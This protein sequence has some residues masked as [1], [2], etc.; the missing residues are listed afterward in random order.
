M[1]TA[2][3]KKQILR[4]LAGYNGAIADSIAVGISGAAESTA[5]T[6]LGFEVIRVPVDVL[7]PD[8]LTSQILFKGVLPSDMAGK[9]YEVGLWTS[10]VNL[11]ANGYGSRV[12][13]SFDSASEDWDVETPESTIARVGV[14]SL[15]HTPGA[16]ATTT[17]TLGDVEVDLSGFS[18]SD[19]FLF[20]VN[21]DNSNAASV[22]ARFRTDAANY[23]S[24]TFTTEIG[25]SGYK[26][27]SANKSAA[28]VTGN[29]SW[30]TINSIQVITTAKA[31]GAA[32]VEWD[33]IRI[34]D[35]DTINADYVLVA[36]KVLATPFTKIEGR[37]LEFEY[38]LD[39]TL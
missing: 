25:T 18:G 14:D 31:A 16:S 24:F 12:I 8:F 33:A 19:K 11:L 36:R 30:D 35:M 38:A 32:S 3:G 9:I 34:E 27:L 6:M 5:N 13:T 1:I 15:K 26:F 23:Y 7:A 17:S 37:A 29:P 22:T 2:Q 10:D 4:Y 39:V 20:A 28:T 21:A